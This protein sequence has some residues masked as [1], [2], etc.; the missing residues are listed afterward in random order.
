MSDA[1]ISALAKLPPALTAPARAALW[2]GGL[3]ALLL[4]LVVPFVSQRGLPGVRLN[5]LLAVGLGVVVG[6]L[7]AAEHLVRRGRVAAG[8]AWGALI[9]LV[10]VLLAAAQAGYTESMLSV[11]PV[12]ALDLTY[13]AVW[14][15]IYDPLTLPV[16]GLWAVALAAPPLA[17]C[18]GRRRAQAA[19]AGALLVAALVATALLVRRGGLALGVNRSSHTLRVGLPVGAE[20]NE[21][22]S[23]GPVSVGETIAAALAGDRPYGDR[24]M[25]VEALVLALVLALGGALAAALGDR[26]TT[27]PPREDGDDEG[28]LAPLLAAP[29]L[30]LAVS[31]GVVVALAWVGGRAPFASHV[32]WLLALDMFSTERVLKRVGAANRSLLPPLVAT[33]DDAASPGR[34]TAASL[35]QRIGP[36]L[37]REAVEALERAAATLD[38][39]L[40]ATA[41]GALLDADEVSRRGVVRRL[42]SRILAGASAYDIFDLHVSL[43]Y[44]ATRVGDVLAELARDPDPVVAITALG[45]QA[46]SDEPAAFERLSGYLDDPVHAPAA[47]QALGHGSYA[48]A[49]FVRARLARADDP[50]SDP[51]LLALPVLESSSAALALLT[52]LLDSPSPRVRSAALAGLRGDTPRGTWRDVLDSLLDRLAREPDARDL[53]LTIISH[54]PLAGTEAE[55]RLPDARDRRLRAALEEIRDATSG[56]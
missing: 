55:R 53:L 29:R 17:R 32:P 8:V 51:I 18:L 3:A 45:A 41:M 44:R 28:E 49:D 30:P 6:V 4:A 54:G 14:L 33:L 37:P 9:A 11:G 38:A 52:D 50:G 21:R 19:L 48:L 40:A 15:A 10:G 46:M 20:L 35:I 47:A 42:R 13:Q 31:A 16:I 5:V 34:F 7:T 1:P 2:R 43:S 22:Q 36:P 26:L 24:P 12:Q 23:A 25:C 39:G 27:A 56:R